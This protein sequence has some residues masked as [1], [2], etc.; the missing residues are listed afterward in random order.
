[1]CKYEMLVGV[2][3]HSTIQVTTMQVTPHQSM[4]VLGGYGGCRALEE[5]GDWNVS[6]PLRGV[7]E[8]DFK[9]VIEEVGVVATGTDTV[10]RKV[11]LQ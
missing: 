3:V 1:M 4:T 7:K 11:H 9:Y 2:L 6:S 5:S 10:R 8:Q